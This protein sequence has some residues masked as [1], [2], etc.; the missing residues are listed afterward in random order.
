MKI[1]FSHLKRFIKDNPSIEDISSKL[2]QLGHENHI[3]GDI[4]DIEFTPNRGDCLSLF[5]VARD[6]GAFYKLNLDFDYYDEPID[7]LEID[8]INNS[9]Q[10]CPNIFFLSMEISNNNVRKYRP[11]LES[12]FY[13]HQ[14]KKNNFFTDI[15]NYL[16]YEIGQPTHCYD[17]N[18]IYHPIEFNNIFVK[19]EFHSLIGKKIQLNQKNCVFTSNNEIINLAGIMGGISTACNEN[20]SKVLIESA[21]FNAEAIIGKSLKYDIHSDASYKFERGIDP[22]LQEIALRRFIKIV[23]DH[24][25]IIKLKIYREQKLGIDKKNIEFDSNMINKI[26]GTEISK[27]K[28]E[29]SLSSIGFIINGSSLEV[30][31]HRH[32]IKHLNDIAEEVAR[33]IGYD[34]IKPKKFLIKDKSNTLKQK[35]D[36]IKD[37]LVDN[38]FNEVI[39]NPFTESNDNKD[40]I[41]VDNPLDSNKSF[42]RTTLKSSLINNLEF[43]EN[44]Q[45]DSIKLFEISDVYFNKDD[46]KSEK[47]LSLIISGRLDN[48]YED[49]SKKLDKKYIMNLFQSINIDLNLNQV[50]QID[51]SEI[52]NK[53][54]NKIFFIEIPIKDIFD[55]IK[56]YKSLRK[57]K[58][59]IQF[60][61]YKKISEY[62]SSFRD[63]SFLLSNE[64]LI[65]QLEDLVLNYKTPNLKNVFI[66]DFFKKDKNNIKLGVRFIFQSDQ[67]TLTDSE[68]DIEISNILTEVN[69]LKG[70]SIPGL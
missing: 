30:P 25:E 3:T 7:P 4:L 62:P 65:V 35:E 28:I 19:E 16:A 70:V 23:S 54:K 66:F 34:H 8:F 32:D 45:N 20:T 21:Y 67:S 31:K 18:K 46:I 22:S 40:S 1:A 58:K 10:D 47:F 63:F 14:I 2:F 68:I 27:D 59:V 38:G 15:S 11:Y 33:V 5:G 39:N 17:M 6:L 9:V 50:E 43:N 41:K 24:T 56:K 69:R 12:Y 26:L 49:F 29:K 44:R 52:N 64:D 51:R 13:D 42:L 55:G 53:I 37:F 36:Y 61:K 57:D 48:N 60:K